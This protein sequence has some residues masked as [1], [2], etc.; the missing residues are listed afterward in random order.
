MY[1]GF[2]CVGFGFVVVVG[3]FFVV[4]GIIDFCF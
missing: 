1:V 3:L 2:L 4:E